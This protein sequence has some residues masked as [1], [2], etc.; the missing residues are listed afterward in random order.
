MNGKWQTIFHCYLVWFCYNEN[1]L[2]GNLAKTG[3]QR[4][5]LENGARFSMMLAGFSMKLEW[6]KNLRYKIIYEPY[7]TNKIAWCEAA[8]AENKRTL[9]MAKFFD[10]DGKIIS[11]ISLPIP[12]DSYQ[13]KCRFRTTAKEFI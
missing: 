3:K 4:S 10:N 7:E 13:I 5:A 9:G 11:Q 12:S 6:M 1:A 2:N 8:Y